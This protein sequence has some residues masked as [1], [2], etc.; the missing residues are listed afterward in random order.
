MR[1]RDPSMIASAIRTQNAIRVAAST[2]AAADATAS[3]KSEVKDLL[4]RPAPLGKPQLA[5]SIAH[6]GHKK[7]L[8]LLF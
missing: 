1:R 2:N 8:L 3:G 7:H 6:K 4:Y 5:E